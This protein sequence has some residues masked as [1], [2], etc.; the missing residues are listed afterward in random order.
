[1][2]AVPIPAATDCVPLI[3]A[4]QLRC[5]ARAYLAHAGEITLHD[6]VDVLQA[7]A[8]AQGLVYILGQDA[9]QAN[10]AEGF[11]EAAHSHAS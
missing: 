7:D 11:E 9:V 10:M 2:M 4:F 8:E 3:D 1:M 6:A 5:W